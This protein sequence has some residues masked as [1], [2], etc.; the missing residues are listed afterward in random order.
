MSEENEQPRCASC[1]QEIAPDENGAMPTQCPHCHELLVINDQQPEDVEY[2]RVQ[3]EEIDGLK[4]RQ[5]LRDRW[6]LLRGRT[7]VIVAALASLVLAVQLSW[8]SWKKR[9]PT[10]AFGAAALLV[11]AWEMGTR[12]RR[13]T[14]E[15]TQPLQTD[16]TSP[17]DFQGL[18]DGSQ[19]ADKLKQI[20][21]QK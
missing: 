17:P 4:V 9:E 2:T 20:H 6:A 11:V 10:Y 16:P 5:I 13:M 18:S 3:E 8:K 21:E 14:R 1:G 15:L 19:Y 12:A 7:Y